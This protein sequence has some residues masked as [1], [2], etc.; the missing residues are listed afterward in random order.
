MK[1][2]YE[3]QRRIW[4]GGKLFDLVF[5]GLVELLNPSTE[6]P[7]LENALVL[8]WELVQHQWILFEDREMALA[9]GLFRLRAHRNHT[10]RLDA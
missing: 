9:D 7:L 5:D 1:R 4:E 6:L 10:V 2:M 3:E 8:L